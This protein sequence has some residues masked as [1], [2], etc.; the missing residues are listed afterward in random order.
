[1]GYRGQ[2]DPT[3][4]SLLAPETATAHCAEPVVCVPSKNE[5]RRLPAL[6]AALDRQGPVG[7]NRLKVLLLLNNTTDASRSVAE[8]AA[9]SA[10]N[11]DLRI[12]ERQFTTSIAHAGSA[13]RAAMEAGAAWLESEGLRGGFLLTTDADA[14]PGREWV[15]ASRAA[16]EAGAD[17]AASVIRGDPAEEARF[18]PDLRAAVAQIA[19]AQSL[20]CALEDAIDP[21]PGDP[22][23]RH[24]DHTGGGLALRLETYRAVGGC[25]PLPVREDLAL[26]DAVRRMGGKVRHCPAVRVTVSARMR[27]RAAG[28]MASTIRFWSRQVAQGHELLAPDPDQQ[29]AH[30]RARASLRADLELQASGLPAGFAARVIAAGLASQVPDPVDWSR[31]IPASA[32]VEELERYLEDYVRPRSAA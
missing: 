5:A 13:R 29:V 6:L 20:A 23:P 27:G 1:M 22:A 32:A 30:W 12:E 10:T 21:I 28:G 25:P 24:S 7:P 19:L 9:R 3:Q 2:T 11:V 17:V 8:D 14:T 4:C 26:I 16:L 15:L 31:Q 18:S